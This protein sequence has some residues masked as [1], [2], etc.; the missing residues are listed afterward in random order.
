MSKTHPT[1]SE[2]R[3]QREHLQLAIKRAHRTGKSVGLLFVDVDD[4]PSLDRAWGEGVGDRVLAALGERLRTTFRD[5]DVS[6]RLEGDEY[7]IVVEDLANPHDIGLLIRRIDRLL[8]QPFDI[9]GVP[10]RLRASIGSAVSQGVGSPG[11]LLNA[12][13]RRTTRAMGTPP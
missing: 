2:A 6:A 8:E 7:V 11:E 12:A 1:V 4:A 9:D 10:V 13:D 3:L 5:T